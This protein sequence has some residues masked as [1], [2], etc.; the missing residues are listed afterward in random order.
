MRKWHLTF[1]GNQHKEIVCL[2]N[3]KEKPVV[4]FAWK[5][6][7]I[8]K[9][10]KNL[11]NIPFS[12]RNNTSECMICH[13]LYSSVVLSSML[14]FDEKN[15]TVQLASATVDIKTQHMTEGMAY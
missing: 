5:H 4:S 11:W 14:T 12:I 7:H 6:C 13:T 15:C 9:A 3:W 1:S 8:F 2:S 10:T